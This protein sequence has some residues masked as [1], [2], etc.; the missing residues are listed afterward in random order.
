M[1]SARRLAPRQWWRQQI[2]VVRQPQGQTHDF[3]VFRLA[4]ELRGIL[5]TGGVFD[6][7]QPDM[8]LGVGRDD[9]WDNLTNFAARELRR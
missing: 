3:Q 8:G 6:P 2:A 9:E 1:N 7:Q 4:P 5:G